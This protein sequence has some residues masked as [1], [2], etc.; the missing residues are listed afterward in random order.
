MLDMRKPLPAQMNVRCTE[1]QKKAFIAAIDDIPSN[2]DM[3]IDD[4]ELT[5]GVILRWF[6][7]WFASLPPE[8]RNEVAAEMQA[9]MLIQRLDALR[10]GKLPEPEGEKSGGTARPRRA[11]G[12]GLADI[13]QR[14]SKKPR[15]KSTNSP[16]GLKGLGH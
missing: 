14:K 11:T 5:N 12:S 3:Y 10:G 16:F 1:E 4:K 8:R 9:A 7:I 6:V 15:P 2:D 13:T